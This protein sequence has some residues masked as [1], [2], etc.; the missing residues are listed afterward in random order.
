M[1]ESEHDMSVPFSSMLFTV[2]VYTYASFPRQ[3]GNGAFVV[4][5]FWLNSSRVVYRY[6][7]MQ[8]FFLDFVLADR[9]ENFEENKKKESAIQ[10]KEGS[11]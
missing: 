10:Y 8:F 9:R 3:L 11:N 7:E 2:S 6:L 5:R 4:L 1:F